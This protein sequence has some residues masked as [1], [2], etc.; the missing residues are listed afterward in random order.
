M[1]EG[2]KVEVWVNFTNGHCRSHRREYR[3]ESQHEGQNKNDPVWAWPFDVG[4]CNSDSAE[5]PGIYV[6]GT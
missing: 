1:L 3:G 6:R 2:R 5:A 4:P